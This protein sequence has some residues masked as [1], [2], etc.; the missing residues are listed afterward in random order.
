MPRER[1]LGILEMQKQ[2][3]NQQYVRIKKYTWKVPKIFLVRKI[4]LTFGYL[5]MTDYILVRHE[6]IDN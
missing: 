1:S 5:W 2:R 4:D 6:R 3:F